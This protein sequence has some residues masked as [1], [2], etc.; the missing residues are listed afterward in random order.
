MATGPT[1]DQ[2]REELRR[3]MKETSARAVARELSVSSTGL[4]KFVDT[5]DSTMYGKTLRKLIPW[6]ERRITRQLT[7]PAAEDV[8]PAVRVLT[9]KMAPGERS[10]SGR[11]SRGC[12]KRCTRT[13]RK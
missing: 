1:L 7:A 10:A 5:A 11:K 3:A 2:L 13:V 8:G 9:R 4:T 6:Y 12:W